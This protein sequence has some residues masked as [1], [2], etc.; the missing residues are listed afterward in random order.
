MKLNLTALEARILGA[1]VEKEYTTPETYPLSMNGLM[2]ACNQKSNRNPVMR[3]SEEELA[4]GLARLQYDKQLVATYSGVGSRVV[5]YTHRLAE[6]LGVD[7]PEAAL[8]CELLLRGAQTPGE[9]RGRASRMATFHTP[10]EVKDVLDDLAARKPTPY[11]LELPRA[12][13]RKES[14]FTHTFGDVSLEELSAQ[15]GETHSRAVPVA[16]PSVEQALQDAKRIQA[17][18][19]RL[20][21]LEEKVAAIESR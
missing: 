3:L 6:T 17:L 18:E 13:G 15:E 19:E 14:R 11:V 9:L 12:P 2:A 21:R 4:R 5:K 1:L 8:L 16:S 10:A 20:D 7:S